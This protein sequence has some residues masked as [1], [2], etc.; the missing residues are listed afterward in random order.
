MAIQSDDAE[1]ILAAFNAAPREVGESSASEEGGSYGI[2]AL[3]TKCVRPVWRE[4]LAYGGDATRTRFTPFEYGFHL[5]RRWGCTLAEL[6]VGDTAL[7]LAARN[8]APRCVRQLLKLGA[9]ASALNRV[10]RTPLMV[11][12]AA[13]IDAFDE[14]AQLQ[15]P[16]TPTDQAPAVL[17]NG[18]VNSDELQRPPPIPAFEY[19]AHPY[20][21][22]PD[23][24]TAATVFHYL[25]PSD[26]HRLPTS[27]HVIVGFGGGRMQTSQVEAESS[28][29][30]QIAAAVGERAVEQ[31]CDLY[32]AGVAPAILL[33]GDAEEAPSLRAF[34]TEN[35]VPDEAL[36]VAE[37][38]FL[39]K[40]T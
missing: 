12:H 29:A 37:V 5:S 2:A 28:G 27:C 11:T 40:S 30:V 18:K 39:K 35:G 3:S 36:Q 16:P 20:S 13:C 7:H 31:C 19:N 23:R 22:R 14:Q 32:H 26:Q 4:S 17:G 21:S 34:A 6:E 33:V 10:G 15:R 25:T 38:F 9:N 24:A 8:A 1:R